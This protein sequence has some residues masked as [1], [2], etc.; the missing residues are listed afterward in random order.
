MCDTREEF[1][2]ITKYQIIDLVT[3]ICI[4]KKKKTK[5]VKKRIID[6]EINIPVILV[7]KRGSNIEK[8]KREEQNTVQEIK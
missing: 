7:W 5:I 2:K 4:C 6:C 8:K 1:N 3:L